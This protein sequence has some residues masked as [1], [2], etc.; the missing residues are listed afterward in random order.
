MGERFGKE[1]YGNPEAGPRRADSGSDTHFGVQGPG[2]AL[3]QTGYS[4]VCSRGGWPKR[5][6]EL[7]RNYS[8]TEQSETSGKV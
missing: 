7:S 5:S 6:A 8:G 1:L 3:C 4:V 2:R